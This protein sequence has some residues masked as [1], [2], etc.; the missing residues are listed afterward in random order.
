MRIPQLV[1]N[2]AI[3]LVALISLQVACRL[4]AQE[5]WESS[6]NQDATESAKIVDRL[7]REDLPES[8]RGMKPAA[9]IDDYTFLR[10]ATLDLIGQLP[11]LDEISEFVGDTTAEKHAAW[12]DRRL[13]DPR[14]GENW[15]RYWRD[16]VM[17]RRTEP[18]ALP[19]ASSMVDFLTEHFNQ[20]T[21]WDEIARMFIVANGDIQEDGATALIAA[22][23]GRPEETVAELA[24]VFLGIQIQCAQCH[25]HPSDQWTR[26]QFHELAAFFPRTFMRP[27]RGG[28]KRSFLVTHRD[29]PIRFRPKIDRYLG[30]LEHVMSDL[31]HP[32]AQGT[33][34]EPVFFVSGRKMES[35]SSDD[36]RRAT[37][38][39]WMT[40]PTNE[41]F[42]KAYVNRI[43]AELI[44][45]GFYDPVDDL[46]PE[47]EP[48]APRTLAYLARQFVASGHDIKWLMRT[49]MLT[50][51]YQRKST[52]REPGTSPTFLSTHQ[53]RLRS[54]QIFNALSSVVAFDDPFV[55]NRLR[56]NRG[57]GPRV[58][59]ANTFG[60]DPSEVRA[61]VVGS[62]PQ[63][64]LLMNG[65]LLDRMISAERRGGLGRLI[66]TQTDD[67]QLVDQL[68]MMTLSRPASK[69]ER[70]AAVAYIRR[71]DNRAD[72]YEDILWAL[73]NSSE[74]IHRG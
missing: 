37:L 12:I 15:A 25:D 38:A 71:T 45:V 53:Q 21:P 26:E 60:Y 4:G 1:S 10:R 29:F 33:K 28:D 39:T 40:E 20:N 23:G 62:V 65:P 70:G 72:A 46:G 43:W 56:A 41:W 17:A 73:V 8:A 52:E 6:Y 32:E 27:S 24:R 36:E 9:R 54:D 47:R 5:D 34:M 3:L 51:L 31:E 64:M 48:A 61:E 18:R 55:I 14:Y 67:K 13:A 19:A 22:Q 63:A 16:V 69:K 2:R 66:R 11:T 49:I 35:G 59:F 68:Y 30:E 42:A 44:G 57:R 74:F 7:L 58:L 50:D